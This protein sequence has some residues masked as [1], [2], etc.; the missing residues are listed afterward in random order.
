MYAW[1][2]VVWILIQGK[3]KTDVPAEAGSQDKKGAYSF[4][5]CLLLHVGPKQIERYHPSW[6]GRYLTSSTYLDV[7]LIQKHPVRHVQK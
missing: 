4:F 2:P 3:E 7:K 5:L 6:G 1:G